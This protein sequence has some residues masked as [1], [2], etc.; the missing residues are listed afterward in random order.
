MKMRPLR[1]LLRWEVARDRLLSAAQPVTRRETVALTRAAGRVSRRTLRAVRPV[2]AFA[3]ATWDG[4]AFRSRVSRRASVDHPVRL[5]LLGELFADQRRREPVPVR[6]AVAV[7]TGARLPPGTDTVEIFENVLRRGRSILLRHPVGP[8]RYVA[9]RGE[10]LAQGSVLA[11]AGEPLGPASLGALSASGRSDVEVFARPRVSLV[12]NGDELLSPGSRPRAGGIFESN[13]ASLSAIIHAGGGV[14]LP[15]P[16]VRDSP[17]RIEAVLRE[18]A[19]HSDLVVA[20]GGSSVGEHDYLPAI[21][22]RLGRLLFHGIAIR[23]GKPTLAALRGRTI[24]LGMP[25]HP[26]SCLGN[27]LWLL[28][29]LVRRLA[30]LPGDGWVDQE[31]VLAKDI[32]P[33]SSDRATLVPLRLEGNRGIPT[34]H[35]SHAITSLA[36]VGAFTILPPGASRPRRGDRLPVHRMLPPLGPPGPA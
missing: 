20:T 8:G 15:R 29:P 34:F 6:G 10:D 23:P 27:G 2:P 13:S 25:G 21:F 5:T 24:F 19:R 4:Y 7:A 14:A 30:R 32:E 16:P 9:H 3:R 18:A 35:D 31:V 11:R 26:T 12:P 1:R 22:P 33:L 17:G 28:L 36:D